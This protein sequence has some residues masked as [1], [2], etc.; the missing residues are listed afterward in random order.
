MFENLGGEHIRLET[1]EVIETPTAT[2]L[3][4][5]VVKED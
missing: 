4:F 2:H 3:L 5:R 1:P